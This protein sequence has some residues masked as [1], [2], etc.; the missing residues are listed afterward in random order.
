MTKN[1][2]SVEKNDLAAKALSI[3]NNKRL[4]LMCF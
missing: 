4:L 2:V 3:M 1:P